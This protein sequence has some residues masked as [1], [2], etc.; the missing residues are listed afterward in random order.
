MVDTIYT[1]TRL[2][3]TIFHYRVSGLQNVDHPNPAIFVANH[4]DSVGPLAVVLSVPIRFYPWVIAEITDIKRAPLYIYNDF[5]GPTLHLTGKAGQLAS[6][7]ISRITVPLMRGLGALSVDRSR[8][9]V[10][11]VFYQSL[12][13]LRAGKNLLIF[14]ENPD[15]PL[16]PKTRMRPFM[17]GF[18]W[19]VQMY[20]RAAHSSLPIYPVAVS[21]KSRQI[22]IGPAINL[23][24]HADHRQE[25]VHFA[26]LIQDQVAQLYLKIISPKPI[27]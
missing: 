6:N 16:D 9:W 11:R 10:S 13:L 26:A 12:D 7:I 27:S 18:T 14:P 19:L 23:Q 3:G 20:A 17:S 8:G 2:S 21:P 25:M 24:F 22:S 5:V 15:L 1:L 4:M